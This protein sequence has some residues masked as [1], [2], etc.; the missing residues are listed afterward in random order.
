MEPSRSRAWGMER[1]GGLP[2][3]VSCFLPRTDWKGFKGAACRVTRVSKKCLRAARALVLAPGQETPHHTGVGAAG[4]GIGD[5]CREEL[6][7]GKP[8]PN[9]RS[10]CA[11][12]LGMKSSSISTRTANGSLG[13]SLDVL[14]AQ[15]ASDT[16]APA[17]RNRAAHA[18]K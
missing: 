15:N 9:W 7:G 10:N 3:V 16:S 13:C 11:Y 12:R 5:A 1:P 2:S 14:P 18:F 6:I 8:S 17:R 4:M